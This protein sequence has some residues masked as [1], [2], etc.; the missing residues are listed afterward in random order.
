MFI[1]LA[2]V[3]RSRSC[4]TDRS[5]PRSCN[6]VADPSA[7]ACPSAGGGDGVADT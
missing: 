6:P 4:C 2:P 5:S 1:G 7:V 3:A